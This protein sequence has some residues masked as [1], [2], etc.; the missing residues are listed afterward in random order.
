MKKCIICGKSYEG[1]GNN[2]DPLCKLFCK[3]A[4]CDNCE[5]RC[6]DS[7]NHIVVSTRNEQISRFIADLVKLNDNK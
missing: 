5:H 7:C 2:P 3:D 4:S 6:C 1:F